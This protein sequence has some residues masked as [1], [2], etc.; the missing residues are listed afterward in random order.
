MDDPGHVFWVSWLSGGHLV[1]DACS[2]SENSLNRK[3][4]WCSRFL[5]PDYL[6]VGI[7][8]GDRCHKVFSSGRLEGFK[9]GPEHIQ[10]GI[11]TMASNNLNN[12]GAFTD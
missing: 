8:D 11:E 1:G 6:A 4:A 12:V 3:E 2:A 7:K 10:D 9:F 5:S